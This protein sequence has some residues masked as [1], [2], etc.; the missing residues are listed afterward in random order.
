MRVLLMMRT[1]KGFF[2]F[3][4]TDHHK[5]KEENARHHVLSDKNY[6]NKLL[7]TLLYTM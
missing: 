6:S 2:N 5:Q 4:V 3:L 7:H 1:G